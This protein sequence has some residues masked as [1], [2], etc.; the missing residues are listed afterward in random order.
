MRG[1]YV[2]EIN[3]KSGKC[4]WISDELPTRDEAGMLKEQL[5]HDTRVTSSWDTFFRVCEAV[6]L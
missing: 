3:R 4:V 1:Y 6:W 5:E 2:Q